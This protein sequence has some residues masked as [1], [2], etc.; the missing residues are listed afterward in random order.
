MDLLLCWRFC[1]FP[2]YQFYRRI[3]FGYGISRLAFGSRKVDDSTRRQR[4]TDYLICWYPS[5]TFN[6]MILNLF[7][8]AVLPAFSEE[9]IFR[10]VFQRIFPKP[11]QIGTYCSL[12]LLHL[13]FSAIHLT[14]F[15]ICTKVYSR[16]CFRLSLFL[17]RKPLAAHYRPFCK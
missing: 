14:V 12:G 13:I 2:D 9:L 1:L 15:W 7:M 5:N 10:G 8:I 6:V 4:Q 17:E 11:F 3:K 16:T